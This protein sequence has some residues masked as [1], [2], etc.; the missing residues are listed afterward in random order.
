MIDKD[1]AKYAVDTALQQGADYADARLVCLQTETLEIRNGSVSGIKQHL[2]VGIG[3]R[4]L[5]KGAWGF[6]GNPD[7]KKKKV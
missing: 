1:L 7:L 6:A 4:V 2:E 5:H 3:I